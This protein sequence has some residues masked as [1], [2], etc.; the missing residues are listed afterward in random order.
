MIDMV[1]QLQALLKPTGTLAFTFFDPHYDPAPGW[2]NSTSLKHTLLQAQAK[3]TTST[4]EVDAL[5][6]KA[7]YASRVTLINDQDV[8]IDDEEPSTDEIGD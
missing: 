8:Y 1:G 5:L 3:R 4:I 7:R 2:S 6:E